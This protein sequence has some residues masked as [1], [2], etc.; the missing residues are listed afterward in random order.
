LKHLLIQHFGEKIMCS[1]PKEKNKSQLTFLLSAQMPEFVD[2]IETTT[3]LKRRADL[4]WMVYSKF[5]FDIDKFFDQH[6]LKISLTKCQASCPKEWE[7]FSV[8]LCQHTK[9]LWKCKGRV[10][11]SS[12]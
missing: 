9:H 7:V 2:K 5:Q 3:I 12:W 11:S 4:L 8:V 1:Y 6:N 10:M